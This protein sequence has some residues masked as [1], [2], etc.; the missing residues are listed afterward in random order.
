MPL[1]GSHLAARLFQPDGS[2]RALAVISHGLES[3]MASQK[4][5]NLAHALTLFGCYTLQFDHLG[6]GDSPGEA[7]RTTLSRRRDEFLAATAALCQEAPAGLPLVY[8]GSS[9]GGTTALLAAALEP[10]LC[11]VHWSAPWDFASLVRKLALQPQQP[12]LPDFAADLPHHD[13]PGLLAATRGMFLVHGERDELVE[14]AQARYAYGLAPRPKGL[15]VLPGA[16]HRLSDPADQNTA[17]AHT[18]AW[19]ESRLQEA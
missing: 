8:L 12:I 4:L 16:D 1:P 2:P 18:L 9:L 13:L 17:L 11:T 6:C 10:P 19:I 3:S 15:V 7:R 5:S 14:V